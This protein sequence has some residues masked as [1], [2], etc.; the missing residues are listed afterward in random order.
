LR[1]EPE[2]GVAQILLHPQP[3][4]DEGTHDHPR[5]S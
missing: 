3:L 2:P 5:G 4:A 1:A